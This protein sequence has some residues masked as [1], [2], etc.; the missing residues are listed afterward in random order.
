MVLSRWR[1]IGGLAITLQRFSGAQNQ[2]T[3]QSSSRRNFIINLKT[4]KA[5]GIA[6]PPSALLRADEVIE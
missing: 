6:L 2:P 5:I 1:R 4:A 3:F